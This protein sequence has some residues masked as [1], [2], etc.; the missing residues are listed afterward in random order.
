[1]S[2]S[3]PLIKKAFIIRI[4]FDYYENHHFE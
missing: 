2:H 3:T 1:M 4:A